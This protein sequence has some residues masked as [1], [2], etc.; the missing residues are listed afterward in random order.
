MNGLIENDATDL[1][2]VEQ[3]T[4]VDLGHTSCLPAE[5][6]LQ[7]LLHGPELDAGT[8][9]HIWTCCSKVSKAASVFAL[10][11]IS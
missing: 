4:V 9:R 7:G 10:S 2:F 6:H 3:D 1:L 8:K 5:K 11:S